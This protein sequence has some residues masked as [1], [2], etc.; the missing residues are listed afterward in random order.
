MA[1]KKSEM[2]LSLIKKWFNWPK[3]QNGFFESRG[4]TWAGG[5]PASQANRPCFFF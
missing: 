2:A 4:V 5:M 1:G 3:S